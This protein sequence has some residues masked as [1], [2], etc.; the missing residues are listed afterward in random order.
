MQAKVV[1]TQKKLTSIIITTEQQGK[2]HNLFMFTI[3]IHIPM[4]IQAIG[5]SD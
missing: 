2:M 3:Y 1:K 4:K 5:E